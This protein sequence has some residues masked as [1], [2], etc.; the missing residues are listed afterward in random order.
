M[1][2]SAATTIETAP[3]GSNVAVYQCVALFD[4]VLTIYSLQNSLKAD[5]RNRRGV[6]ARLRQI[7]ETSMAAGGRSVVPK[8][9]LKFLSS[10]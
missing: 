6:S 2:V 1:T 8:F 7:R 3:G 5:R 10:L 9:W 4:S